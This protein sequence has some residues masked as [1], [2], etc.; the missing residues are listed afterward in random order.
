MCRLDPLHR[1][2]C[3]LPGARVKDVR[4]K[5]LSLVQP[6]G[7]YR[8]LLFQVGSDDNRKKFPKDYEKGLQ[9]LGVTGKG[10]GSTSCVLL[11][12]SSYREQ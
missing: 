10:F 4:K 1:E 6:S 9:S 3:C 2:V 11:Y 12:P 7:F 8:L 5:L